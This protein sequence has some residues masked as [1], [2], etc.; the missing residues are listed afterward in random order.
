[1][2]TYEYLK[3]AFGLTDA[4]AT[5]QRALDIILSGMTWKTC[6]VYLDDV[7]VFSDTPENLVKAL[8]EALTRLGRAGVTLQA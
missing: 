4:P 3:M 7:I 2:G 5:L 8:D 1:M 6:L